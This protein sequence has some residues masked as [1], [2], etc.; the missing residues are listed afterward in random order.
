MTTNSD[1]GAIFV[2]PD[3]LLAN[4]FTLTEY[5]TQLFPR[6]DQKHIVQAVSLYSDL[7]AT[8]PDQASAVMGDCNHSVQNFTLTHRLT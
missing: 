5:I 3:V 4:N 1:E 7:G 6:L 2:L 8:V